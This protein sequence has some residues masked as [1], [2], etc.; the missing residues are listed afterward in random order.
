MDF[1]GVRNMGNKL[2][3]AFLVIAAAIV[4][5]DLLYHLWVSSSGGCD[6]FGSDYLRRACSPY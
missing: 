3:E 4:A 1:E 5:A 2:A 6:A